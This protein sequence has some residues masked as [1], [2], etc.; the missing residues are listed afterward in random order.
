MF[1]RLFALES[2]QNCSVRD[3]WVM[4]Y[5]GWEGD[6]CWSRDLR[7]RAHDELSAMTA[8]VSDVALSFD[9]HDS[10]RWGLINNG[11]FSVKRLSSLVDK[12]LYDGITDSLSCTGTG[13]GT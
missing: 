1:P 12:V 3:R 6:W 2:A 7:G 11:I 10:W 8:S 13:T 9:R 5:N 4:G